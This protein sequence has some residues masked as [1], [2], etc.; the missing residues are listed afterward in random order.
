MR[1]RI[2]KRFFQ[3]IARRIREVARPQ[4][5]ILFGSYAYGR[6]RTGSDI[7]LLIIMETRERPVK[8][9]ENVSRRL[10]PQ[11]YPMDILVRT[12]AEVKKRLHLGD[13]FIREVISRGKVL[14]EK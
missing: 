1:R 5:V 9:A 3:Q 13:P 2:P 7:D 12:P 8:R 6:P 14:Y 11:P 4:K 10:Y